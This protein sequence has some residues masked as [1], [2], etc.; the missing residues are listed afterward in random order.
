MPAA[1]REETSPAH[2]RGNTRLFEVNAIR[3]D[4]PFS[5]L[6]QDFQPFFF[7]RSADEI[8]GH[9]TPM[10]KSAAASPSKCVLGEKYVERYR[11]ICRP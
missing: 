7:Q 1:A 8:C 2:T 3:M 5:F 9:S 10:K 6:Q 11:S 4:L